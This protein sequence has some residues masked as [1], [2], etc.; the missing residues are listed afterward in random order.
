MHCRIRLW[1]WGDSTNA[2]LFSFHT[3]QRSSVGMQSRIGFGERVLMP[4]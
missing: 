3:I 2:I 4:V 1:E